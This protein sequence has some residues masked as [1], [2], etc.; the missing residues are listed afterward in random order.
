MNQIKIKIGMN[1]KKYIKFLNLKIMLGVE[2][3]NEL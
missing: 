1:F 3:C 2:I